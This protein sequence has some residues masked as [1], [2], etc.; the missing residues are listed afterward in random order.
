MQSSST[1]LAV[2]DVSLAKRRYRLRCGDSEKFVW[3]L[4]FLA[5]IRAL[6]G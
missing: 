6:R 5:H 2:V 4:V 3:E 1:M